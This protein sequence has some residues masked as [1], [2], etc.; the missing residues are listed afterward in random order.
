M[1]P[2]VFRNT[3]LLSNAIFAPSA[4]PE[5]TISGPICGL[6]QTKDHSSA[7][8]AGRH[9]LVNTIVKGMRVYIPA[10][11]SLSAVVI[12]HGAGSGD[13][14]ADLRVQMPWAVISDQRRAES[15]SNHS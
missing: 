12:Y 5:P 1:I 15:V 14:V 10:R 2:S 11:R 9:S 7:P 6:I 3:L 8:S 13:A 4:S